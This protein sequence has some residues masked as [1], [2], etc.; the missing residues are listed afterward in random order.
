MLEKGW[1]EP[2]RVVGKLKAEEL[3]TNM[4][5]DGIGMKSCIPYNMTKDGVIVR[6]GILTLKQFRDS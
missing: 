6:H 3:R 2:A 4:G 5:M 1:L